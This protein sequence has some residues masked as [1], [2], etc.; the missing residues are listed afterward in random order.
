MFTNALAKPKYNPTLL[1]WIRITMTNRPYNRGYIEELRRAK[2]LGF[3]FNYAGPQDDAYLYQTL[4]LAEQVEADYVQVRPA[5][6]F[7]GKTVDIAP[8]KIVHPLLHV[9]EYK[10]EDAKH[11]H[12]YATC[13]AYH[14][15]P[16]VW[17]DGNVDVCSYMRKY[18]GYRLG[19][20][21]QDNL[22]TILDRAPSSVPVHENCQVCCKLHE[23]NKVIHQARQ[24]E[25]VDFP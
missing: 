9:T 2:T 3:A 17:E 25:D 19:N 21:Y 8:P 12:G 11:K 23:T 15:T 13:E 6:K 24:L 18:E 16:F 1:D 4:E 14:L 10:F 20:L 22:Q 7:H 5:L